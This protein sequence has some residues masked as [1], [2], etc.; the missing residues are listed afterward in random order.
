[1]TA[2]L[3]PLLREMVEAGASDLFLAEGRQ[4]S[5]RIDGLVTVTLYPPTTRDAL[6]E[7]MGGLLRPAQKAEFDRTGDLD[8]GRTIDDLGRFRFHFHVQRGAIGAVI[9]P[10][11]SGQL[12]FS[13]LGLPEAI[14][15]F[16]E[17]PRGLVLVTGA[18]G[19]GKSTTV[20]AMVHHI[21]R[22]SS[23]HIV[24]LED[25]IEFV[26][27]DML[28]LVTQREIG[29]DTPDFAS[30][31]R[32]V[33]RE[34]PDVIVIGEM[35]DAETMS[36]ALSAA[37]TG[38]LVISTLH[39]VDATQTLQRILGYFP[40]HL[41][42]QVSMDLS[43]SLRG[44]TAQRLVPR[45][46]SGGGRVPAVEILEATPAIARLIR[47]QR[48]EEV[49]DAMLNASGME[50]FN[51]ALLRLHKAG[52]VTL[53]TA[54][55]YATNPDELRMGAQGTTRGSAVLVSERELDGGATDVDMHDLLMRALRVG[56][57]D[58][59]LIAGSPPLF[60]I[61]G[62]LAPGERLPPLGPG[63]VRR[64]LM[65]LFNH[66]Q[67]ERFDLEHE[68]D[69]ALTVTGGQRFRVNAHSQRGT[70]A[71]SIRLIPNKVPDLET[72]GLPA[73]VQS[74]AMRDQGL[75]LVTGPTGSG[76][77]T[78]LAAMIEMIN[79]TRNCHIIT[80]EDPIEFL[81]E[82]KVSTIE[83]REI[84][85]DSKSFAAALKYILR[86]DPDVILVGELRDHETIAAA[87]TAAETGHLVLGTL[88][89]N[90]APQTIDRIV[91]VFPPHQQSQIRTQLS[92]ELLAIIAQRLLLR[93]GGRGRVPAFEVMVATPAIRR[94]IR[95]A[96]THQI[97][98]SM[99]T[100][101][102]DGMVTLDRAV[103]ELIKGGL[104]SVEE[105]ARY[106]RNPSQLA[107]LMGPPASPEPAAPGAPYRTR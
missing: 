1:M 82:N 12:D 28:S 54:L 32:N 80:I 15:R 56:A 27:E 78:T 11:P 38:H 2:A 53:E 107:T 50:S 18:T 65:S 62:Q 26:H 101:G 55:A 76:K 48:V 97:Q 33:L 74:L 87:L 3:E 60:R 8:V 40:E 88:H 37:L 61:H 23:K 102:G 6:E 85:A 44:I 35:R 91:D 36:V 16:A 29:S 57:S 51:G 70:A 68:L 95:D 69:F 94:L 4:P 104:V 13:A 92:S 66:A 98:S 89:S 105:G 79:R 19:S 93:E 43:L 30:G 9:R 17:A 58:L 47:E 103:A 63:T 67:R 59:H 86:Q 45:A 46:G 84:G 73:V 83:Q 52:L 49:G 25:P 81:H 20:A 106:L 42:E 96:K 31:L 34:S 21:N 99:E 41:R 72:L 7:L 100:G 22:T 39:T 14:T 77:S 64:L 75:V 10:V 24:T 90:D 71:A 5:W